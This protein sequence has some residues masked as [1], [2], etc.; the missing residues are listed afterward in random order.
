MSG[1]RLWGTVAAIVAVIMLAACSAN[2][3]SGSDPVPAGPG[4]GHY[5]MDLGGYTGPEI[6]KDRITLRLM[7]QSWSD[8]ANAIFDAQVQAFEKAYPNVTVKQELVP[9]GDL[10]TKLQTYVAAGNVPDIVMGRSDFVSAYRYGD[11]VAP[12][13]DYFTQAFRADFTAALRTSVTADGH[14]WALPWEHQ[15][16]L[17]AYN[18]D[19]FKK[20]GVPLP[21]NSTD[22]NDGWTAEQWFSAFAKLRT[23][24]DN[25]GHKRMWPLAP[26]GFGN[27]GPGSNYAQLESTWIRMQGAPDAPKES[28]E[29]KAFTG[30]SPDGL[31]VDGYVNNPLAVA[32]M[33]NY[34]KLFTQRW[35]PTDYTPDMFTSQ[36]AAVDVGGINKGTDE[37]D[38]GLTPL[39]RVKSVVSSNASDSLII[40][41]TSEHPA[42]AAALLGALFTTDLKVKWHTTWGS[43]PSQQTV[44][45]QM[46][47][48]IRRTEKFQMVTNMAKATVGAPK[49]PGW[50]EYFNQMNTTVRDIAL[51]ADVQPSLDKAASDIDKQLAKYKK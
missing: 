49:T 20:A 21:P 50:F 3:E 6:T 35:T 13:G 32:G 17:L 8:D 47:S 42:E 22:P 30:V 18:K 15:V 2:A 38:W 37:F 40:S 9:Y 41:R 12:V 25:S 1:R 27:G 28:D 34:Q 5:K 19:V 51:G 39:P 46:P 24:M 14:M 33:K 36:T 31:S 44:I 10:S 48:K 43:L 4:P 7:R 26:S 16:Q 23:W 11:I 45:K 29:Y